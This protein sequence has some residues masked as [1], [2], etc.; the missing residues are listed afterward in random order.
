MEASFRNE[1]GSYRLRDEPRAGG[2]PSRRPRTRPRSSTRAVVL[3][4]GPAGLVPRRARRG[5]RVALEPPPCR[6]VDGGL[7]EP[8]APGALAHR[9]DLGARGRRRGGRPFEGGKRKGAQRRIP[10]TDLLAHVTAE[11]VRAD[12]GFPGVGNRTAVLDGPVGD[13]PS[14]VESPGSTK[15]SVGHA[16][17]QR[18]QVPQLSATGA[19]AGRFRSVRI[20]A[21]SR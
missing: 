11:D 10:G 18:V 14:G 12:G 1:S 19:S 6:A 3:E 4:A 8:P 5:G 7:P 17:R 21:S 2:A 20:S 15:A 13:A 16:S 9:E